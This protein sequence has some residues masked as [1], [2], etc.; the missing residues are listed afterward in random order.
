MISTTFFELWI[1]IT[2]VMIIFC[3]DG[4]PLIAFCSL[5]QFTLILLLC[6]DVW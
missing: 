6:G 3:S 2:K 4:P 5:I 1:R